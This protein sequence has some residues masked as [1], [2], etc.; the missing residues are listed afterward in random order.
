MS[1]ARSVTVYRFV[2]KK[3]HYFDFSTCAKNMPQKVSP[4]TLWNKMTTNLEL[5][6]KKK[7]FVQH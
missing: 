3:S 2:M 7:E 1:F 6:N 5:K 4:Q